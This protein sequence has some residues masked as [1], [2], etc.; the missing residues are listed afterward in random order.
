MKKIIL[1]F[2]LSFIALLSKSADYYWVGGTGNW[3]QFSTHWATTSGGASFRTQV[4]TSADNVFFDANSFSATGQIV[5]INSGIPTCNNMDWTGVTNTP[6][7]V[8]NNA[9][10]DGLN[11]YGSL[12][13]VSGMTLT[14][15]QPTYFRSTAIGKTIT[16]GGK[17][18][19]WVYFEGAGGWTFQDAFNANEG[20][21]LNN[22]SLITNNQAVTIYYFSC[23]G[24]NTRS[25]DLGS[26]TVTISYSSPPWGVSGSNFT[27]TAGTS[28]LVFTNGGSFTGGSKVYYDITY[29]GATAGTINGVTSAHNVSFT[30]AGTL[31][32]NSTY[33][34]VSFSANGT[35]TGS[36]TFNDLSFGTGRT[37][38]LTAATTQTVN[39]TLTCSS[40]CSGLSYFTS[41]STT[42]AIISKSSGSVIFDYVKLINIAG[43]GGASFTANNSLSFGTNTGWTINA[44]TPKTLFWVGGTGNWNE[45]T[46]W[47]LTSGGSA[48]NCIPTEVDHVFFDANSF[49]A[50]AQT[51]TI[52]SRAAYC[53]NMDWSSVTNTP[54]FLISNVFAEGVNISG[55]LTYFSGM[56]LTANF[57]HYFKSTST[58][59]TITLNGKQLKWAYFDGVGGEWTF[60]DAF[61][62][63]EGVFL[64]NGSL[65]TNNQAVT[66]YY[67]SSN[68]ANIRS[69]NVGSSAFILSYSQPWELGGSNLTYISSNPTFLVKGGG[70]FIGG[71]KAYYD[72]T[73]SGSSAATITGVTSANNIFFTA[74][75]TLN[76]TGATFNNATFGGNATINGNNTFNDLTFYSGT[77][78]TLQASR[79]QTINGTF[80][81]TGTAS[82]PITITSS[83]TT[84]I[85]KASGTV[86]LD[87]LALTNIAATGGATFDAGTNSTNSGST[88]FVFTGS[89]T[90]PT[91]PQH[92][93]RGAN[94]TWATTT[95]WSPN[96]VPTS[97]TNAI[98]YNSINAP[99]V[100]ATQAINNLTINSGGIVT[101]NSSGNLQL[102]GTLTNNG[103]IIATAGTI[104][105]TGSS[106]QTIPALTFSTN[107]VQNLIINNTAGVTLAGTL[108]VTGTLTPTAGTLNTGG[109][110]TLKSNASGTAR[111][112]PVIG[113]ISGNVTLERYLPLGKRAYRQLA[114]GVT[115]PATAPGSINSNWQLGMHITGNVGTAGTQDATTGF[116]N[117]QTGN[118]NMFTYTPDA[119]SFTAI[120]NTK[121]TYLNAKTGYRVFVLGS[122]SA[123]LT[124]LNNSGTGTLNIASTATT[125]QVTGT[126][127]TGTQTFTSGAG[128]LASTITNGGYA[129]IA[130]PY[131]SPVD[132]DALTKSNLVATYWLWN[133]NIGNRGAYTSWT[134]ITGSSGGGAITKD[135]QPGQAIFVQT[136]AN[137]AASITFNEANKTSGFTST[138][139][140]VGLSPSKLVVSLI[141]AY[142]TNPVIVKDASTIAFRDDFS[143]AILG[144]EDAQKFTNSDEN[145]AIINNT[146]ALG[147]E[148]RPT[149]ANSDIIPVRLWKLFDNNTYSIKL[150]TQDFDA[151]IQAYLRDKKLNTQ[152]A[153]S[154][155]G[156]TIYP[157][158]FTS[159]DSSSFYNRFEIVF[160]NTT[161]LPANFTNI[162][163][164]RKNNGI[165]VEWDIAAETAIKNYEVQR[166][167][168]AD[169]F[170][171]VASVTA[172]ANNGKAVNYDWFDANPFKTN[173]YYRIK[174]VGANG[175]VKYSSIV[176]VGN[177]KE[178]EKVSVYPNPLEGNVVTLQLG[179]I[180]EGK[181]EIQL[182]SSTGQQMMSS[183]IVKQG[184]VQTQT[185]SLPKNM[186]AGVYRL[187]IRAEDGTIYNRNIIKL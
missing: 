128:E 160:N 90:L 119:A 35:I 56:T 88:G 158:T 164:Y 105:M 50:S 12:T 159:T 186:S 168:N 142:G 138:F 112:A 47:S 165:Q 61:N 157:F 54:T 27:L 129:L 29:T 68:N 114:S 180:A 187:S 155:S 70:S 59:K 17:T 111:I 125:I 23:S 141:G 13:Y 176:K 148:A 131:W 58:G 46:H 171:T 103:T 113:S 177:S 118:K 123:D 130:N 16:C 174:V 63:N 154:M 181:Y 134:T 156:E 109:F 161:A 6:T 185:L 40:S 24:T 48:L 101:V 80:T 3:T 183:S 55:S 53:N 82:L 78:N 72:L 79:T 116:D 67:F 11:I 22:G 1:C 107:T 26:S 152:T 64:T 33:N 136:T 146:T 173:N 25:L 104:S 2:S 30:Q 37:Y 120:S 93:W 167:E 178:T 60:Q 96:I 153:I 76:G 69:L 44:L 169:G 126:L 75:A 52:N 18:M 151:G 149:V 106:A 7:F 32:G 51:V 139:R 66:I 115:T 89:C 71:S 36:N 73:F 144:T 5:T 147:L 62:T 117:T 124:V 81:A 10:N 91:Y 135:I 100:S 133:P 19:K 83:A 108:N 8:I 99:T 95:N 179:G 127:L 42:P 145:I 34:N 31:S 98:I 74:N 150:N 184:A 122:R 21:F 65:I 41:T 86:C 170:T 92:L 87:R 143:T 175:E 132:W 28:N 43:T 163:A 162:K 121:T 38:T 20:V 49:S 110:L 182:F 97:A 94:T 4:P 140:P 14:A 166:S 84:T 15:N 9:F 172:T 137:G 39:G 45:G 102:N 85:S 77:T 57:P